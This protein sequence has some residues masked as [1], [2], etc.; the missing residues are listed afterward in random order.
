MMEK[1]KTTYKSTSVS[2]KYNSKIYNK[3]FK[4]D[5][6]QQVKVLT[7]VGSGIN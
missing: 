2:S 5:W 7:G 6:M 1:I 3:S 4:R